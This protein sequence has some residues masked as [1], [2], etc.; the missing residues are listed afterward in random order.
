[1]KRSGRIA[2]AAILLA[3]IPTLALAATRTRVHI[4]RPFTSGGKPRGHVA[5][6]FTAVSCS[7][8][9]AT[10]RR[11]AWR[12]QIARGFGAFLDDPCFSSMKARGFVLCPA[13]GPWSNQV[14][15]A[16][17]R[18]KLSGGNQGRPSTHGLPW[19]LVTAR[20]WRCTLNTGATSVIDGKR[21]NYFCRGMSK[22]LWGSPQQRWEP[23]KIYVAG[24]H[25]RR[26]RSTTRI[27][28]AWF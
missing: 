21:Q 13:T 9:D 3:A 27:R 18:G 24:N 17:L 19:A 2:L 10:R 28:T 15:E 22:S 11:D 1:V 12:C 25:P 8:S 20:G 6:G 23:W 16:R 4:Y 7:G 5:K 26:L 14:I